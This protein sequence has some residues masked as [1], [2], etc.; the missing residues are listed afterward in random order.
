VDAVHADWNAQ[1]CLSAKNYLQVQPFSYA[2]LVQ[3]LSSSF[4]A[5]FTPAEAEY[6]AT[7]AGI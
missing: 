5:G 6:G 2:G 3:Q 1:A 7:C 4:G